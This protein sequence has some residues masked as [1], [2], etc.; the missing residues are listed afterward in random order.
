ML[1]DA[2]S[3]VLIGEMLALAIAFLDASLRSRSD[4]WYRRKDRFHLVEIVSPHFGYF[5]YASENV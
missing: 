5:V 4:D 3:L 2:G 1:A